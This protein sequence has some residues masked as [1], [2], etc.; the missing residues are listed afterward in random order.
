M[1]QLEQMLDRIRKD[2]DVRQN[3]IQIR[4]NIS[5]ESLRRNFMGL[6][7]GD[8]TLLTDLLQHEDPKVRKNA[9]L[10]LGMTQDEQVL[11]ALMD[12]WEKEETLYVREDYLKAV[13]ALDYRPYI[14]KMKERIASLEAGLQLEDVPESG[15]REELWDNNKH[16]L[17]ELSALRGMVSRY[18]KREKHHF[19]KMNPAPDLILQTNRLHADVTG[20][21]VLQGTVNVMKGSVHVKGGDLE[22]ILKIRTWTEILFPIP[23]ARPFSGDE[24]AIAQWLRNLK[25]ANYLKYLHQESDQPFRYRIELKSRTIPAEKRGDFIRRIAS[26]LDALEHGALQNTD[27]AYEAE[28]RLIERSDGAFVPMLK[29]YTI[30][31]DRFS[32]RKETTAQSTSAYL[33]AVS[34]ELA[35]PYL[36]AGAQVLDPFCGTGTLLMERCLK[37]DADPVYGV[38]RYAQ[39]L[40]KAKINTQITRRFPHAPF[41]LVNRDFFDFTHDY[42]FDEII[43]HFPAQTGEESEEAFAGRFLGKASQLLS[44]GAML[45][46][47]T[48]APGA[49]K[50]AL[51]KEKGF[52]LEKTFVLNER[53]GTEEC[54]LRYASTDPVSLDNHEGSE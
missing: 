12:A 14:P 51:S 26:R 32:Y 33:A 44:D 8:F 15:Q 37:A 50:Q 54:I 10:I 1:A 43:T 45:I 13:S 34:C 35:G 46:V 47:L 49:L 5:D 36:K 27:S 2:M 3:L 53:A 18:E 19:S 16:L 4:Q 30:P 41:H 11:G 28:I 21:Q 39:A 6:L 52:T 7:E 25:A 24:K 20:R 22:E 29:L 31:D 38:D 42:R 48:D 40:E 23:G 9:A 17:A